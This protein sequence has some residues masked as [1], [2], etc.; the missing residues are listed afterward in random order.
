MIFFYS[1]TNIRQATRDAPNS[2]ACLKGM[3]MTLHDLIDHAARIAANLEAGKRA[4]EGDDAAIT[5]ELLCLWSIDAEAG[6]DCEASSIAGDITHQVERGVVTLKLGPA[7]ALFAAK[8][9]R[10]MAE[11]PKRSAVALAA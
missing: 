5:R 11:P 8:V 4:L 3:T 2:G 9:L 7:H 1:S 10:E 6:Y